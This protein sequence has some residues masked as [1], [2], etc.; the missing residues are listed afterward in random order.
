M[1]KLRSNRK[2][3]LTTETIRHLKDL[4]ASDL[5]HVQGGGELPTGTCSGFFCTASC[6]DERQAP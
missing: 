2:L 6:G 4:P 3:T 1:K 5:H